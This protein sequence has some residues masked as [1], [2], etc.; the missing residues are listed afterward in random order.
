MPDQGSRT[1]EGNDLQEVA[2]GHDDQPQ[3]V[4]VP[5]QLHQAGKVWWEGLVGVGDADHLVLVRRVVGVA[6]GGVGIGVQHQGGDLLGALV[7]KLSRQQLILWKL[8]GIPEENIMPQVFRSED[9][10]MQQSID[11]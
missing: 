2:Q 9:T 1:L 7:G 6:V 8:S 10:D 3:V 4:L 11:T 5:L